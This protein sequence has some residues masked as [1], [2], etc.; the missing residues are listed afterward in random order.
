ML[1][2]F[3]SNLDAF[4]YPGVVELAG[5]LDEEEVDLG[6]VHMLLTE[7]VNGHTRVPSKDVDGQIVLPSTFGI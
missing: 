3:A 2:K 4:P 1:P 7:L 6:H 5:L